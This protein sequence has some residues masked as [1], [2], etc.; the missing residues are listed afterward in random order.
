MRGCGR[1]GDGEMGRAGGFI[2]R[3]KL[4]RRASFEI[5]GFLQLFGGELDVTIWCDK[6]KTFALIMGAGSSRDDGRG[7]PDKS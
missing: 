7:V 5:F 3:S 1:D 6:C 4:L 2:L